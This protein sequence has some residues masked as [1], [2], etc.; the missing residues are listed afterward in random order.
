LPTDRLA[1]IRVLLSLAILLVKRL[2][3]VRAYGFA[4]FLLGRVLPMPAQD[5]APE[6]PD[7]WEIAAAPS[8]GCVARRS[9]AEIDT[10]LI[11][12]HDGIVILIGG[13]PSWNIPTGPRQVTLDFDGHHWNEI[14]A[15]SF[16][17]LLLVQIK[18]QAMLAQL[19][20]AKTITWTL[21]NGTFHA[22]VTGINLVVTR[23]MNCDWRK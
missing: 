9:G 23:I 17:S 15:T 14:A 21:P 10:M 13:R 2:R 16:T 22:D 5:N 3:R 8:G 6:A 12:N 18:D 1:D 19:Q 4:L 20:S 11:V 7:G